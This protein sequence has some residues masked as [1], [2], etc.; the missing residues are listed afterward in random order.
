M[1]RK[2]SIRL[3]ENCDDVKHRLTCTSTG[4]N[5]AIEVFKSCCMALCEMN[6]LRIAGCHIHSSEP[7]VKQSV[8][9]TD[10]LRQYVCTSDDS[11]E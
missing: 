6:N 11:F 9:L 4:L 7:N 1:S 10:R 2:K 3:S 8:Q 5:C